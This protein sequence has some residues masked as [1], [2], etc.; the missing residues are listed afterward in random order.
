AAQFAN[1]DFRQ[2]PTK[3]RPYCPVISADA[4]KTTIIARGDELMLLGQII[5][6]DLINDLTS[7]EREMLIT[8]RVEWDDIFKTT[9]SHHVRALCT[10]FVPNNLAQGLWSPITVYEEPN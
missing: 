10:W 2:D 6:A 1:I 3:L 8:S 4:G 9:T 7:G 5:S